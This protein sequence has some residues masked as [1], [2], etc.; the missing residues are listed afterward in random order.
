MPVLHRLSQ[1]ALKSSKPG[2]F[3]D[4]GGLWLQISKSPAGRVNILGF[5]DSP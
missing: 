1:A 4:G 5:S 3:G 2:M